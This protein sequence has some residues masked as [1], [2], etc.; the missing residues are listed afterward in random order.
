MS[1]G[2]LG[3]EAVDAFNRLGQEGRT[4]TLPAVLILGEQ[5]GALMKSAKG[6]G[7]R[8]IVKMPLKSRE[9]RQCVLSAIAAGAS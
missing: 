4:K 3:Q 1:T 9:L 2:R 7:R 8:L 5:Q 6:G